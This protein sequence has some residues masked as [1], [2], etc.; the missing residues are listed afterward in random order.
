MI[1]TIFYR[2]GTHTLKK[3]VEVTRIEDDK[4]RRDEA[5]KQAGVEKSKV[6]GFEW[7]FTIEKELK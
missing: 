3:T 2:S 5:V 4:K 1:A 7:K 6:V